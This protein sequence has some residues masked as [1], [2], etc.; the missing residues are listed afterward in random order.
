[1]WKN[2]PY[3]THPNAKHFDGKEEVRG[4]PKTTI[5]VETLKQ[6]QMTKN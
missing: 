1:M 5:V 2:H 3:R 6:A 4:R